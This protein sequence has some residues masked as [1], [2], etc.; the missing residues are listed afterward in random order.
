MQHS[1]VHAWFSHFVQTALTRTLGSQLLDLASNHPPIK[2]TTLTN[3]IPDLITPHISLTRCNHCCNDQSKPAPITVPM[4]LIVFVRIFKRNLIIPD[5]NDRTDQAWLIPYSFSP[6]ISVNLWPKTF[7]DIGDQEMK[8]ILKWGGAEAAGTN[9]VKGN[10][11]LT[12]TILVD[13]VIYTGDCI[14]WLSKID[15]LKSEPHIVYRNFRLEL[16]ELIYQ[17]HQQTPLMCLNGGR[18]LTIWINIL[19]FRNLHP[20][21]LLYLRI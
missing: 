18:F 1:F 11:Q 14:F 5:K 4:P 13:C 12:S 17:S 8:G 10:T 6:P 16:T 19:C 20:K 9:L 3:A 15:H 21:H 7:G 2:T